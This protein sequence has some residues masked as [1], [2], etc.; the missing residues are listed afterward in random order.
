MIPDKRYRGTAEITMAPDISGTETR[1]NIQ[2]GPLLLG[3]ALSQ[4]HG[5]SK[6]EIKRGA[7]GRSFFGGGGLA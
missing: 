1:I 3:S 4:Q 5:T 2:F 7:G 6:G